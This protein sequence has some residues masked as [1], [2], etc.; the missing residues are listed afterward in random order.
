[1][2]KIV[3]AAILAVLLLTGCGSSNKKEIRCVISQT[4]SG[5]VISA[6]LNID[7]TNK[8]ISY[9]NAVYDMD[10]SSYTEAQ[11]EQVSQQVH[12]GGQVTVLINVNCD[13][14]IRVRFVEPVLVP[15][16]AGVVVFIV[17]HLHKEADRLDEGWVQRNPNRQWVVQSTTVLVDV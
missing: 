2:K 8:K 4:Q 13:L 14:H 16:R 10:L 9:M 1:M 12:K 3:L 11:I 5:V 17:D 15:N 6:K 7:V